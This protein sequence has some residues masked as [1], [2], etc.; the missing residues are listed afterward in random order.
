MT[1]CTLG[2]MRLF[3]SFWSAALCLVLG[4][5]MGGC[6]DSDG[7]GSKSGISSSKYLDE[8]STGEIQ[9]LCSW[10]ASV[11]EPG[12]HKCSGGK[13]MNINTASE[14]VSKSQNSPPPHC[15]VSLVE[16]C[17]NSVHGDACQITFTTACWKYIL[18]G[19]SI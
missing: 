11:V 4:L 16:D 6:D 13:T 15:L 7:S 12:E 14:C 17:F 10:M 3:P 18:C 9:Q 1:V 19:T 8:L 5:A 2:L